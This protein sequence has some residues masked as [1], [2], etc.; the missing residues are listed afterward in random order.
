MNYRGPYRPAPP[1]SNDRPSTGRRNTFV[2][3][4]ATLLVLA[5]VLTFAA[6][7]TGPVPASGFLAGMPHGQSKQAAGPVADSAPGA[8]PHTAV[9]P[10]AGIQKIVAENPD[11]RIGVAITD[12]AGGTPQ[13][14]GDDAAYAA[15]S[16]A[17]IL[18]AA[19][20]YHL[21]ETG[22]KSLDAPLGSFDAA[23]QIQAMVN[24]S[25]D[26]SWLLLM[27][28]IGYP[29]LTAYATSLGI[30]YDPEENLLTPQDMA[31]LLQ[32][33]ATGKLLDAGHT[34]ELLGYMQQTNDEDLIPAALDPGIT[35]HHKYGVVEGYVHDAALLEAGGHTYAV[36]IYTWGPD[37]A[38]S[39]A[40]I[41]LIHQLTQEITGALFGL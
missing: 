24:T 13:T 29:E 12:T 18:T 22:E 5:A 27:R 2:A 20:Y 9:D 28:D 38:D 14:Y 35:V 33:L 17:K 26:D 7:R 10:A 40:R 25:S 23:F 3:L 39:D 8:A 37:D 41:D 16:T 31:L 36:V 11:H 19:A 34:A 30:D 6:V 32:R 21:V 4:A 1:A 15:A